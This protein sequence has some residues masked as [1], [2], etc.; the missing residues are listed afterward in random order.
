MDRVLKAM[1]WLIIIGGV[2]INPIAQG[3]L[4][5]H[6][7]SMLR[8]EAQMIP[9]ELYEMIFGAISSIISGA[10]LLILLDIKRRMQADDAA[11]K[12]F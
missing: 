2:L 12:R 6:S 4:I 8:F 5:I 1:A 9:M 11:S 10:A 7:L 3:I